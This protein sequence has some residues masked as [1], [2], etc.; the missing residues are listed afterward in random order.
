MAHQN[1][2][3]SQIAARVMNH[4]ETI[5]ARGGGEE[6][7]KQ[8]QKETVQGALNVPMVFAPLTVR[9]TLFGTCVLTDLPTQL[10]SYRS[11]RRSVTIDYSAVSYTHLTLPTIYSV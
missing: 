10:P 11:K 7:A 9:L 5:A 1:E 6:E 8:K 2:G 3:V 4:S